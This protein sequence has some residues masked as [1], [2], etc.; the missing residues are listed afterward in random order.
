M[1]VIPQPQAASRYCFHTEQTG[2]GV[3]QHREHGIDGERDQHSDGLHAGIEEEDTDKDDTRN[4]LED[5]DQ[6][7]GNGGELGC[8]GQENAEEQAQYKAD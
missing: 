5:R 2:I 4:G 7:Q 1:G 3:F 6:R 8:P